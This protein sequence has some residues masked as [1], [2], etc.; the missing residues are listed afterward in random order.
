LHHNS[1]TP[2]HAAAEHG[3]THLVQLLVS[4]GISVNA[5]THGYGETA[6]HLACVYGKAEFA[7]A[8][9][10]NGAD[11][12]SIR[13]TEATPALTAAIHGSTECLQLLAGRGADLSVRDH[14]GHTLLHAAAFWGH[15]QCVSLLLS[16]SKDIAADV[17]AVSADGSVPLMLCFENDIHGSL[18]QSHDVYS[19]FI[20]ADA[21]HCAQSLLDNGANVA[22]DMLTQLCR[23]AEP[24]F[25]SDDDDDNTAPTDAMRALS[26]YMTRLRSS[27]AAHTAVAAVHT[28][29]CSA[30]STQQHTNTTVHT[31][32]SH[33]SGIISIRSTAG[34]S[35]SSAATS[36]VQ[37]RSSIS[38]Q[39]VHAVTGVKAAKLYNLELRTLERLLAVHS[40][41][42]QT[43]CVLL[44][45][46][47]APSGWRSKQ[48]QQQQ[49]GTVELQYDGKHVLAALC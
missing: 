11:I 14:A 46:L 5:K 29:A 28:A 7:E 10:D 32:N 22:P 48:E 43:S 37:Q 6:L 44:N 45:L 42:D 36:A 31:D 25:N 21:D 27:V 17:N 24:N 15:L 23:R 8:L 47:K 16:Y 35:G 33:S 49:D 30:I 26:S 13:D 1:G 4:K 12:N 39:L 20:Q 34:S 2:L 9:L 18:A 38:V 3:K 41:V 40:S 19:E